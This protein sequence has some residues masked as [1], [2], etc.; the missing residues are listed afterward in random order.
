MKRI[1]N[2]LFTGSI[3]GIVL[4]IAAAGI[5]TTLL[6]HAATVSLPLEP[7]TG[8]ISQNTS[9]MATVVSDSTASGGKA[10]QFGASTTPPPPSGDFTMPTAASVGPRCDVS[11][12]V[13]PAQALTTLR[14][15]GELS[16]VTINGQF[17]LE[18]S[19][20]VNWHI[21]DVRIITS[22]VNGYGLRTYLGFG[23]VD[24]FTGTLAQ[25]PVFSHIEIVGLAAHASGAGACSAAV[26]AN[27]IILEYADIY[28]CTDGVKSWSDFALRYS[29][30]HD[31]DHP[32][33]AHSDALQIVSGSNLEFTGDR[34]DGYDGY[35]S[36]GTG[37]PSDYAGNSV[38]QTGHCNGDVQATFTHNWFAGGHYTIR[39]EGA[40]DSSDT[41]KHPAPYTV[42]YVF[43]DN[44]WLRHGTSVALGRSDLV[45]NTYGPIYGSTAADQDWV[46]NVW[47]DTGE[48]VH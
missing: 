6:S 34:F 31:M 33:G 35:S 17:T 18:G 15:T 26:A 5:L 11:T 21:T 40:C 14:A 2:R 22:A 43:H 12:T 44:R 30:I 4:V 46:D 1:K 23:G 29:W 27:D 37:M 7:E 3:I 48:A 16:C 19:D 9:G 28:G 8:T 25:R 24:A 10:I 41:T 45:P 38:L 39:G 20:G 32:S 42:H 36:D 13:T 47:D